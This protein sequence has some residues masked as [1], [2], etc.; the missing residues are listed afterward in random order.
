MKQEL[1]KGTI[2]NTSILRI[3]DAASIGLHSMILL[4]ADPARKRTTAEMARTLHVSEAHLSKVLQRLAKGRFIQAHRGPKGGFTLN[5]IP[6]EVTVAELYE[7]MEGQLHDGT[8]LLGLNDCP[9][10]SCCFRPM[11]DKINS[12]VRTTFEKTTIAD[13]AHVFRS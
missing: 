11:L 12:I 3:S 4:A 7:Y 10:R 1:R 2:M 9:G 13:V 5:R 6:E 8:C